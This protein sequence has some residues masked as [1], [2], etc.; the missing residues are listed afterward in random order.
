MV[1]TRANHAQVDE[2]QHSIEALH[3]LM[4]D[5]NCERRLADAAGSHDR[6]ETCCTQ[7]GG[8]LLDFDLAVDHR[9][10]YRQI[11]MLKRD[12]IRRSQTLRGCARDLSHERIASSRRI[13]DVAVTFAPV[14]ERLA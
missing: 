2:Q 11:R 3:Q 6:H 13:H 14:A 1:P 4:P 8:Y 5:R 9:N 12:W 7:P 10:T